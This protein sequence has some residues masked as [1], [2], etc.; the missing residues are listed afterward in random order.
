MS[1]VFHEP[2]WLD[3]AAPAGWQEVRAEE[4][5]RTVARMPY[6]EQR[7]FGMHLLLAPPLASR[8][9]PMVEPGDGRY[10][11]RLRRF[12]SVVGDLID[13]LPVA[14]L[15]R[16]AAHPD[17][18]SWLPFHR[19]GFRVEPQLSYVIDALG[20]IDEVW[21]GISGRTRRV[22]RAAGQ[23][24]EVERD[25]STARLQGMV[26]DTY[27]RQRIPFDPALL[28]RIVA[29]AVA[30]DRGTVL[31]ALDRSG[32][33]HASLFGVW[34]DRRAWYLGGGGDPEL[35]SSGAGSLL[36]WELIKESAK[37]VGRF[38]FE[39]SMHPGIERYFRNFGGRQETYFLLTRT[40]TRFAPLW[41]LWQQRAR[42]RTHRGV[43]D[44]GPGVRPLAR[45]LAAPF[46]RS[47]A[48]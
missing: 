30:R 45:A 25:H 5:D 17:M 29:A 43:A 33:V 11:T 7:R 2:W 16:Q 21:R 37:H 12:D 26:A 46:G 34:D 3:A 13:R 47:N 20:D 4:N 41:A 40:S 32:R 28:D 44:D 27:R 38:D 8:L 1:S 6:V 42:A 31:T 36:M 9:G 18:L 24:V 35:R 19:R 10:E 48:T 39:G 14:D 23:Q 22:I 15:F